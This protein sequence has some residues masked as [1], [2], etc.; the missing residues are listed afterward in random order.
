MSFTLGFQL[1]G[2]LGFQVLGL[3]VLGSTKK[4]SPLLTVD[5]VSCCLNFIHDITYYPLPWIKFS[6]KLRKFLEN[7]LNMFCKMI[8]IFVALNLQS[9]LLYLEGVLILK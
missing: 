5:T 6:T 3:T 9:N 2:F 1:S 7:D 4:Y 8:K